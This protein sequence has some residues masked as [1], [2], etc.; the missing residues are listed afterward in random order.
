MNKNQGKKLR[1]ARKRKEA[2]LAAN[3]S[4]ADFKIDTKDHRFAA[5]LEGTDDKFG[6]DPTDPNFKET[7]AMREIMAERTKRRRAK[8]R[9]RH[10]TEELPVAPDVSA[11][12]SNATSTGGAAALSSLVMSLKSKVAKRAQ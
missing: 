7:S 3:V 11:D 9:A 10:L 4:G 6:I 12:V 8:K 2:K 5:V 1:G